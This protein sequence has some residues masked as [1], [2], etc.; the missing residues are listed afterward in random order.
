VLATAAAFGLTRLVSSF[1]FGVKN[2]DPVVFLTV[3]V[4]LSAVGLF[5][6]WIPA[7]CET[8]IDPVIAVRY[9]R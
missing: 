1:L 3:P 7:S 9:E 5:A 4:V 2:L 6:V 8:Q